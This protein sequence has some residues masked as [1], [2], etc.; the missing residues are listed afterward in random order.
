MRHFL[1]TSL[2]VIIYIY[3]NNPK[4]RLITFNVV[5]SDRPGGIAEL[6]KLISSMG[7]SIKVNNKLTVE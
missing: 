3:D 1:L 2:I 6:A 5:V 7:V 4:G